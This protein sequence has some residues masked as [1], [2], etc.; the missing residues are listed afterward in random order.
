MPRLRLAIMNP[1]DKYEVIYSPLSVCT[2]HDGLKVN[3]PTVCV[4][5]RRLR[6]EGWPHY[7]QHV[8]IYI[9][10]TAYNQSV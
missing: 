5:F 2:M 3:P 6:F 10:R 7:E 9:L 1:Y 4:V 8:S